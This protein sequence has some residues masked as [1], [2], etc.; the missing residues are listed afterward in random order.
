[1]DTRRWLICIPEDP[2]F[3]SFPLM[4]YCASTP[5][6]DLFRFVKVC[7]LF[8]ALLIIP[9]LSMAFLAMLHNRPTL[10]F[11]S[12]SLS[13]TP[14]VPYAPIPL[15]FTFYFPCT[16]HLFPHFQFIHTSSFTCVEHC[17]YVS[18]LSVHSSFRHY[19][20]SILVHCRTRKWY[21]GW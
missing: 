13:G 4:C 17:L 6:Q 7:T 19:R 2:Q 21:K 18:R 3:A 12:Y 15:S 1:M 20:F 10:Y 11:R 5:P 16:L 9:F 8:Y 14:S